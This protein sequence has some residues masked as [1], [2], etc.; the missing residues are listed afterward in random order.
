MA[1]TSI[2][3]TLIKYFLLYDKKNFSYMVNYVQKIVYFSTKMVLKS[4]CFEGIK[5]TTAIYSS[6]HTKASGLKQN[7]S[8]T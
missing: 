4:K 1:T 3:K 7:L 8:K 2:R 6:Q 5:R